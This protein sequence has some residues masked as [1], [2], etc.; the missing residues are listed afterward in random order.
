MKRFFD[1]VA[2][3]AGLVLLSPLL[4]LIS[5]AARLD[6]AGPVI[7]RQQRLGRNGVP[8]EILKFRTMRPSSTGPSVT[9]ADDPRITR[10]GKILRSTK[11][12]ELPQLWNILRGDMSL[13]GPRPEVEMFAAHWTDEQRRIILSIRPGLTDP[14]S[15][16]F[17]REAE[18]LASHE[19]P[20]T[21]YV[22]HILPA[23][24]EIYTSYVAQRS[25]SG[26]ARI[27]ARTMGSVVTR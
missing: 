26:D 9:A 20:E 14:A 21:H 7:Y 25:L 19:N 13:V 18:I 2:A 16:E 23:K 24:A 8:F 5:A 12:D 1:V 17:R 15:L 11:L 6:S 27:I 10:V 3:V 22:E 4:G